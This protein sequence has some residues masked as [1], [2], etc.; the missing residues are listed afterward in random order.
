VI[1]IDL[2]PLHDRREDIPALI[3]HLL[4]TR[5]I[6]RAPRKV[7]A[8]SMALLLNYQWPGNIREL[9]NVLERAQ[10]L[11]EGDTITV[12]DL[13]DNLVKA[14]PNLRP[15]EAAPAGP[16]DLEALERRHVQQ[17][18]HDMKG[19]KVHAAKALGISRRSLYRMIEKH[20][21]ESEKLEHEGPAHDSAPST[22]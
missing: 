5:Q 9:V 4:K 7:D 17:V 10:I 20:G 19:N 6:G 16:H 12:D 2:P 1:T 13:P 8:Q 3:D 21:L 11:A 14:T 18:L 22:N 15:V